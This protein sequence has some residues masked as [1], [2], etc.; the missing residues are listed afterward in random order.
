MDENTWKTRYYTATDVMQLVGVSKS[1]AY[2]IIQRLNKELEA[3]GYIM[4][5]GR[6]PRKYFDERFY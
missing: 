4:I 1:K 5:G 3:K 6:V 2:Q